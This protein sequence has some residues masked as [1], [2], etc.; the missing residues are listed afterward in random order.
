MIYLLF[1]T[2]LVINING[3]ISFDT[4]AFALA[5]PCV[6]STC[7]SLPSELENY[8]ITCCTL[9][10]PL[11]YVQPN[12]TSISISMTRFSPPNPNNNTLNYLL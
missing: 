10:V 3:A 7:A 12:Q 5:H 9:S 6:W 2:F 11:N 1:F 8:T 4:N